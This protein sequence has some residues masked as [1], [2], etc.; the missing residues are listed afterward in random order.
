MQKV[1]NFNVR[2]KGSKKGVQKEKN[3][4]HEKNALTSVWNTRLMTETQKLIDRMPKIMHAI[5]E[6]DGFKTPH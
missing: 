3:S 4:G 6:A 1:N 2:I 5:I